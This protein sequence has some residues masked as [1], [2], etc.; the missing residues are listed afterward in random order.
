[1]KETFT[2]TLLLIITLATT[3]IFP[4][5]THIVEVSNNV[6]TPANITIE[7]GDTVRWNNVQ[8]FHNVN[9]DDGSFRSGNVAPAPWTYEY[10]FKS[11][12]NNPYYCEAHGGA[13]GVGMSG[14]VTVQEPSGVSGNE[15]NVNSYELKQNYPNPF[16][17][18]TQISFSL[19]EAGFVTLKVYNLLGKEVADLVSERLGAGNHTV[20]FSGAN[21][22]SGIYFYTLKT[23]DFIQTRKMTLLK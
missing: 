20:S 2:L 12:G 5:T 1:M 21:L 22:Q 9:A 23:K 16:N 13:G 8:G 10:V 15:A 18:S 17:P 19:K 14:T 11:P 3:L 4:Q 7:V 6:F